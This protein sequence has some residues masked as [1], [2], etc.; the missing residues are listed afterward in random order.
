MKNC[1]VAYALDI[2]TGKWNL[3]ILWCLCQEETI[4]FNELRRKLPGI[5][6]NALSQCLRQ[7][8]KKHVVQRKQYNEIPPRVEYSLTSLGRELKPV[9]TLLS[10]WG[11]K[12]LNS[13]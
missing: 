7:L 2:L 9:I 10:E 13:Q 8:E 5:S 11:E 12:V 6:N 4:R 1:S 3:H